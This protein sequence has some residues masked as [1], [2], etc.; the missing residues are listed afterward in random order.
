MRRPGAALIALGV[1]VATLGLLWQLGIL[2]GS[3]VSLPRPVALERSPTAGT[4]PATAA[5]DSTGDH[6]AAVLATTPSPSQP[7]PTPS[8]E[9]APIAPPNLPPTPQPPPPLPVVPTPAPITIVPAD[10][11]DRAA[12]V[13][14]PSGYAVRLVIPTIDLDTEVVQG[15]IVTDGHGNWIWETLPFVAVHYGDLTAQVGANGNAVISGHVVTID[16]GNVFRNL[17][18]LDIDDGIQVWDQRGREYDYR[19]ANVKLVSPSDTSAMEPTPD[20][21]LTLITCGGTFD[22][23]RREFSDRLIVTAKPSLPDL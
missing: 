20:Q 22:R 8:V 6:Q 9:V 16:E 7:V 3:Q 21:T 5:T 10:A 23:V 4:A 15:G 14:A 2:P 12:Q 18:R 11:D 17:Y 19:V 13:P 1:V